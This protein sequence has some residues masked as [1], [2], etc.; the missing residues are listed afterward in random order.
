MEKMNRI[1]KYVKLGK[2]IGEEVNGKHIPMFAASMAFFYFLSLVPAL[3]I[4][5]SFIPNNPGMKDI[6]IKILVRLLPAQFDILIETQI[7]DIFVRSSQL[8]PMAG[9]VLLWTACKGVLSLRNGLNEVYGVENK[10]NFF[11]L[12]FVAIFYT[13]L[14]LLL[15]AIALFLVVIGWD[16][17]ALVLEY[18]PGLRWMFLQLMKLRY[19]FALILMTL[20]FS[21]VY[22]MIP[23]KKNPFLSQIPGAF[24]TSLVWIIYSFVFSL[25]LSN[26]NAFSVY[27]SL[28]VIITFMVWMYFSM[29]FVLIGAFINVMLAKKLSLSFK[30]T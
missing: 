14:L 25:V 19:I 2:R 4:L 16:L 17:I 1:R 30:R 20:L 21:G 23:G 28:Y 26:T 27:G 18:I 13:V 3:M 8:L 15:I 22:T 11:V 5:C 24:V 7:N 10:M 9:F 12:R 6:M 29:Y